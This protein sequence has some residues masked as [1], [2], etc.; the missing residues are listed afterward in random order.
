MKFKPFISQLK[1]NDFRNFHGSVNKWN[2]LKIFANFTEYI[3]KIIFIQEAYECR[4]S[5][6]AE[7]K[8]SMLALV[9]PFSCTE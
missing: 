3:Q 5:D 7:E 1:G 6:F 2:V 8:D 4:L 9:D